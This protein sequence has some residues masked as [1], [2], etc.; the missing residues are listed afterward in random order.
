MAIESIIG[1]TF[2]N[3]HLLK[4]AL[5]HPSCAQTEKNLPFNYQRLEFLGDSVL[6]TV[7]AELL[8]KLFPNEAEGSLA[9]RHSALVRSECLADVARR[10]EIGEYVYMA[11]GEQ[12]DGGRENNSN[13]EDVCESLIGAMYLDGG[14]DAARQFVLRHWEPLARAT[15]AP[16]KDAKTTLQEW[17]QGRGMNLPEYILVKTT[18]PAHAPEFTIKVSVATGESATAHANSKRQAEQMAAKALLEKLN[19]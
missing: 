3:K 2:K 13:L 1:Y 5:T 6:S 12:G 4:E 15:P 8:L 18:G 10:L 9:K 16:P 17:A 14:F 19:G 11:T 7:I